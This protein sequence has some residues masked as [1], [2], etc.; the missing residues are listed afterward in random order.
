MI[1]LRK[2]YVIPN[3]NIVANVNNSEN[4]IY[5]SE[6]YKKGIDDNF[7]IK[8]NNMFLWLDISM[9]TKKKLKGAFII[10]LYFFSV[11]LPKTSLRHL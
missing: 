10:F 3:R 8:Q 2:N 4:K 7:V 5:I 6:W 11:H 1:S 9:D